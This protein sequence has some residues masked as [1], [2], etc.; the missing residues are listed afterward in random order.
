MNLGMINSINTTFNRYNSDYPHCYSV[1][2]FNVLC[3]IVENT[4]NN[5]ENSVI[6]VENYQ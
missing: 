3:V 1:G 4:V 6:S 5:N 2:V